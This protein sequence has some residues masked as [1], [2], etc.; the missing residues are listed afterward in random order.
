[1]MLLVVDALRQIKENHLQFR[2][3]ISSAMVI[4]DAH[5]PCIWKRVAVTL[6]RRSRRAA[7]TGQK[8][9]RHLFRYF[10]VVW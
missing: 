3:L 8:K 10:L 2:E 5:C 9:A 6:T 1:M 7:R 4:G